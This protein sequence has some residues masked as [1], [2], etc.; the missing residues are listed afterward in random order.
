MIIRPHG[1]LVGEI[2][3][4]TP[5]MA[6]AW[7]ERCEAN[8][9]LCDATVKLY[10]RQMAAG[11]WPING[12]T[13][14][15]DEAGNL[16]DGQH[17]LWAIVE[18]G[19]TI[20]C[21]VVRGV[22]TGAFDTIDV[23]K[24]RSPGDLLSIA[25]EDNAKSL[26]ASLSW[27]WR[28]E[29]RCV[30]HRD[31]PSAAESRAVLAQHPNIRDHVHCVTGVPLPAG[32]AIALSYL[33]HRASPVVAPGFWMALRTGERLHSGDPIYRLREAL[34]ADRGRSRGSARVA[35]TVRV[36]WTIKAFNYAAAGRR[37]QLITWK[38]NEPFPEF[39]RHFA[40]TR[41]AE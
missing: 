29:N 21:F 25:G 38:T 7:L 40:A 22:A 37:A 12:E 31:R 24:K 34:L 41:A 39:E 1:Q 33:S 28:L 2:V 15:F 18:S 13:I 19:V 23:G 32:P 10:A 3:K 5:V 4:I 26:A 14:K 30:L 36:A 8:R 20:E 17:R 6:T 27:L 35:I 16:I 11:T 9:P